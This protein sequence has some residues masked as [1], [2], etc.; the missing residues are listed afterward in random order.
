[1]SLGPSKMA[2]SQSQGQGHRRSQGQGHSVRRPYR[3]LL[4][5]FAAWKL[6]LFAIALGSSLIGDAY[7]TSAELVVPPPGT[8]YDDDDDDAAAAAAA[9][10]RVVGVVGPPRT[11]G[12]GRG[13]VTR[14]A[15]WDAIYFVSIARRG[16]RFEQEWAFGA[17]LPAVVRALLRGESSAGLV[18]SGTGFLLRSAFV[19]G[20]CGSVSSRC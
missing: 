5:C 3:T 10:S 11:E 14:L 9:A 19:I 6:F 15:S 1:M 18:V 2:S 4:A 12:L 8:D 13:L 17:G 7:D 16:Y 20:S